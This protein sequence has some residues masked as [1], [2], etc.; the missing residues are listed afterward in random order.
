MQD[1]TPLN[2]NGN[3]IHYHTELN[4]D[5]IEVHYK[6]YDV[7]TE[8]CIA[9]H[10]QFSFEIVEDAF[11]GST[12]MITGFLNFARATVAVAHGPRA[13]GILSHVYP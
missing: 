2:Y 9:T 13:S 8:E 5:A 10:I 7:Q 12:S 1:I 3:Q 6:L 11:D 4:H